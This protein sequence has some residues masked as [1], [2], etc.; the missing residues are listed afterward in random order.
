M[1]MRRMCKRRDELPLGERRMATSSRQAAP[2]RDW[3]GNGAPANSSPD[4][5]PFYIREGWHI[6]PPGSLVDELCHACEERGLTLKE[7]YTT[8]KE[9]VRS[10]GYSAKAGHLRKL[11][12]KLDKELDDLEEYIGELKEYLIKVRMR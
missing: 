9:Y 1:K 10:E 4:P 2:A 12:S 5:P 6:L 11:L 8:K 3:G 7:F